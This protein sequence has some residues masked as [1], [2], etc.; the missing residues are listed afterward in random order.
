MPLDAICL[1]GITNEL[2]RDLANSRI[3]KV[4]QPEKDEIVLLLR[5]PQLGNVRLVLSCNANQPRV[6][7]TENQKENPMQAPMFCMLLR[8]NLQGGRILG[9]EQPGLERVLLLHISCTNEF[10]DTVSRKLILEIMGRHSNLILVGEDG[11]IIDCMR[12]VDITSSQ[13]RQV[14]P[15]L[16]YHYPPKQDG[17]IDLTTL[18]QADIIPLVAEM[19]PEKQ[20]DKWLV[21]TF[22]G[23]SPL[24]A[25]ELVHFAAGEA[26]PRASELTGNAKDKLA[27][28]L[29]TLQQEILAQILLPYGL[30]D[31]KSGL[32]ADF[33]FLELHQYGAKY[34]GRF[35]D[36]F[37]QLLDAYYTNKDHAE[38]MNRKINA[39]LKGIVTAYER[40]E[41]KL[42]YQE[43]ELS[44]AKD[45][46]KYRIYGELLTS[47]M[48]TLEKGQSAATVNNYYTGQE[49]RVPMDIRLSPQQNAAKYFKEYQKH[50]AA[51]I[52]LSKQLAAGQ[53]ELAYL[54]SVMDELS[55]ADSDADL[56]EIHS[57]L[58]QSGYLQKANTGKKQKPEALKLHPHEYRTTEGLQVLVGR[59]NLQNDQ[60]TLK[61]A[62]KNDLWFH[63]KGFP[64][65]HTILVTNRDEEPSD[66]C[67]TE[68][69]MIAAFHSKAAEGVPTDVDYTRVQHVKKP[70]SA[71]PGMVIY[72]KFY[73]ATVTAQNA[74]IAKLKVRK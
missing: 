24:V 44:A 37:S 14:L 73:T 25:R 61:T 28:R 69:A 39:L 30:F 18:K 1:C 22:E 6:H 13:K 66:R 41:R 32:P 17:K 68:A 29:H 34:T 45:R 9:L 11:R 65:S 47:Q 56:K 40:L 20:V 54:E 67:Y 10:G 19:P 5:A 35:F 53:K 36:T 51:E 27:Y 23:L 52:F 16:L 60:L 4:Q 62:K 46:E 12:R 50:K 74:D 33:S 71:Q 26:S 7:L 43:I 21:E 55:R 57:E 64:G 49:E 8:K 38:R 3:D 42:G 59:N 72:D 63:T 15:G 58:V 31:T 48:H 2:N 70:G